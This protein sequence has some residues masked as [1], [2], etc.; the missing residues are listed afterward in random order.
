MKE[1]FGVAF[2]LAIATVALVG[3]QGLAITTRFGLGPGFFIRGLS[4]VLIGLALVQGLTILFEGRG[5]KTVIDAAD[6]SLGDILDA[7]DEPE[8]EAST[9]TILRFS[10]LAASLFIYGFII[11]QIGFV[12]STVALCWVAMVVLGRPPL[13]SLVE[14]GIAI[15]ATRILFADLLGVLLPTARI[16]FL[17]SMGL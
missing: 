10:A 1:W 8:I 16:P 13:R 6:A 4:F 5:R 11:E 17:A 14:A 7:E 2:W 12:L 15:V 9:R 3:S